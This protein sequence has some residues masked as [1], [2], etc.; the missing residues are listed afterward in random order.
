MKFSKVLDVVILTFWIIGG[1]TNLCSETISKSSYG[2]LLVGLVA[3]WCG[4]MYFKHEAS[5]IYK[6]EANIKNIQELNS[7]NH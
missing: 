3:A 6:K 2:A 1:I 4:Y 5:Q 7:K